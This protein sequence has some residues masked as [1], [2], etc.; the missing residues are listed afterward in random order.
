MHDAVLVNARIV[1]HHP[2]IGIVDLDLAQIEGANRVVLDRDFVL[3][4]G[5]IVGDRSACPDGFQRETRCSRAILFWADSSPVL[6]S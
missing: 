4:A 3:L 1:A 5:A 2:E 6:S